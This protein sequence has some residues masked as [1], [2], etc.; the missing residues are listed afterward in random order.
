MSVQDDLT[1]TF[2][3]LTQHQLQAAL[4]EMTGDL[5][6]A[7]VLQKRLPGWMITMCAN[8]CVRWIW[9]HAIRRY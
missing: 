8:W 2:T 9:R 7:E 3:Q 6:K 5:A 4:L 1:H